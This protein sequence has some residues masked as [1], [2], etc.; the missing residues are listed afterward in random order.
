M[1]YII[2]STE[3]PLMASDS[4][5]AGVRDAMSQD[6]KRPGRG[7]IVNK[8]EIKK[9]ILGGRI[10]DYLHIYMYIIDYI[11]VYYRLYMCMYIIY[12]YIYVCVCIYIHTYIYVCMYVCKIHTYLYRHK[13]ELWRRPREEKGLSRNGWVYHNFDLH[14]KNE[15]NVMGF[16]ATSSPYG[17]INSGR[18]GVEAHKLQPGSRR[19]KRCHMMCLVVPLSKTYREVDR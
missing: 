10:W 5:K 3:L 16:G 12:I 19:C 8:Q 1:I 7:S 14:R 15:E 4:A 13:C 18:A 11:Y 2:L 17:Q 9:P 6:E